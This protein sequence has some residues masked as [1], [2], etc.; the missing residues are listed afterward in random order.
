M[1]AAM[2]CPEILLCLSWVAFLSA[3]ACSRFGPSRDQVYSL[4]EEKIDDISKVPVKGFHVVAYARWK[5]K[6]KKYYGELLAVDQKHVYVL[7]KKK[8]RKI[9]RK[10]LRKVKVKLYPTPWIGPAI[11]TL[12]G[13]LTCI[14]HG[15]F[16]II[17]MPSWAALGSVTTGLISL[18]NILVLKGK[19]LR[20]LFEYAR[21]PQGLPLGFDPAGR[22]AKA[23]AAPAAREKAKK[24][25][26]QKPDPTTRPS[27]PEPIPAR[28]GPARPAPPG[29]PARPVPP[30]RPEPSRPPA[31]PEPPGPPAT[32]A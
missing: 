4:L 27:P 8:V 11:Y 30:A 23:S 22:K 31:R 19:K 13:V 18:E 32:R 1:G 12:V 25:P 2:R 28:T 9:D 20:H 3:P 26:D 14:S 10:D 21:F 5:G 7:M 24:K 15:G 16:L 29:P 17:T 6:I